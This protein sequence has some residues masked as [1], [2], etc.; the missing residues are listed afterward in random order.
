MCACVCVCACV[1]ACMHA[2]V[3]VCMRACVRVFAHACMHA[4]MC[5]W[6]TVNFFFSNNPFTLQTHTCRRLRC[7]CP[8]LPDAYTHTFT[9][10]FREADGETDR[11]RHKERDGGKRRRTENIETLAFCSLTFSLQQ[12][13][14]FAGT[15]PG[16]IGAC[17]L[18]V[19][20]LTAIPRVYY[21]QINITLMAFCRG[22]WQTPSFLFFFSFLRGGGGGIYVGS[23][24]IYVISC[25]CCFVKDFCTL[26][27]FFE[28]AM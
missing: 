23:I 6:F 8:A 19:F 27:S 20:L 26:V 21:F 3:R 16:P 10:S 18:A 22:S 7:L 17:I 14:F 5:A 9:D 12:H 1:R 13:M 11:R 2:Y 28:Y 25:C 4:C 24:W 15:Q